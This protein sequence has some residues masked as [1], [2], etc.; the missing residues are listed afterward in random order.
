MV[1]KCIERRKQ[2]MDLSEIRKELVKA[3]VEPDEIKVIMGLVDNYDRQT[4]LKKADSIKRREIFFVGLV[5]FVF[6]VG[7]TI[8]L[9]SSSIVVLFYG[10]ILVGLSMMGYGYSGFI[11][12]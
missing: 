6:G 9:T 1:D 5:S 12:K 11:K 4:A 3:N 10:A 7:L 8:G 2:G